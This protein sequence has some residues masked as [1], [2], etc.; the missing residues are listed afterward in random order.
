MAGG[1]VGEDQCTDQPDHKET[2]R[3]DAAHS[4][5]VAPSGN[6]VQGGGH[7]GLSSSTSHGASS[8]ATRHAPSP[9]DQPTGDRAD[10][11]SLPHTPMGGR[12][13]SRHANANQIRMG[14]RG[15]EVLAEVMPTSSPR[16][17]R[18]WNDHRV[19]LEA[20]C[21]R[22]KH[23]FT[24]AGHS[25]R[26]RG[27]A[28][29]LGTT[30]ALVDRRN[31]RSNVPRRARDQR[32]RRRTRWRL[33]SRSTRP[34]CMPTSTR[35]VLHL[36][37]PQGAESNYT[38]AGEPT[39]HALGRSRGGWTT[40]IRALVDGT[41]APVAMLLTAGQVGDNPQLAPLLEIY[42]DR[43][44]GTMRLLADKAY[45]HPSTRKLLRT[46]RIAHTI[47]ERSD[48]IARRKEKGSRGGRP[49][50]FDAVLYR[51]RNTV[52]RGFNRLKHWRGRNPLRQVRHH[53]P[54][55]RIPRL[56]NHNPPTAQSADRT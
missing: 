28:V 43:H 12:H 6:L 11:P 29:D 56:H 34:A 16:R 14:R 46:K 4:V 52:E 51:H 38:I 39:D 25:R 31:L 19:T 55:R 1:E 40:K 3:P 35:R 21:W 44:G 7:P 49:P 50:A 13:R 48:Q 22:L 32:C 20:I 42:P 2:D 15:A 37:D 26:V 18:P 24:V 10:I 33:W 17:G 30:Q 9:P 54:R 23:R 47:R 5:I 53:L 41:C 45:S 8:S 27:L 36:P